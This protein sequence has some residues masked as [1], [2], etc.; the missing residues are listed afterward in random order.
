MKYVSFRGGM[1]FAASPTAAEFEIY[2]LIARRAILCHFTSPS[3][4]F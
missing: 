1:A 2:F 3:E 4:E